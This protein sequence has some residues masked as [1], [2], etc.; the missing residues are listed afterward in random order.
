MLRPLHGT[1]KIGNGSFAS[2]RPVRLGGGP[3]VRHYGNVVNENHGSL[4][5]RSLEIP[6]EDHKEQ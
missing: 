6:R 3:A 1:T 4:Q 5:T 2:V